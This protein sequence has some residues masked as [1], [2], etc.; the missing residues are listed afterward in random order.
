M[1]TY[2]L[3]VAMIALLASPAFGQTATP[4]T[5]DRTFYFTQARTPQEFQEAA[6]GIRSMTNIREAATDDALMS[7]TLH[8]PADQMALAQWLY[9]EL[10]QSAPPQNGTPSSTEYRVSGNPDDVVR[11]SYFTR[12]RKPQELVEAVTLVRS[13]ANIRSLFIYNPHRADGDA[14]ARRLRSRSQIV[15]SPIWRSTSPMPSHPALRLPP[16]T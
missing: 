14:R 3:T 16:S 7:L 4:P 9:S 13:I 2:A 8:G 6:T 12:A 5:V 10:D 15:C 1:R 11:V